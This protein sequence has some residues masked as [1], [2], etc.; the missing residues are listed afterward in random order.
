MRTA[1]PVP[2]RRRGSALLTVV[3]LTAAMAVLTASMLRYTLTERRG[4]E[5]NRLTLRAKNMAESISTYAAEQITTK[6]YRLRSTSAI[7]FIGGSNQIDPPPVSFLQAAN[8][9]YTSGNAMDVYA[10]LTSATGLVFVDPATKPN[11]PN[12]GLQVNTASVPIISKATAWHPALGNIVSYAQQDLAVDFVPL[13]QFAVFYNMDLEVWPGADLTI[14]G[15]VHV[16]GEFSARSQVGLSANIS[17]LERTSSSRGFYADTSRQGSWTNNLGV[18]NSGAG[19]DGSVNFRH[20]TT[21]ATTSVK[22]SSGVWRD[23][24]YG[25]ASETTTTQNNF[26]VFATS[27]YATNLRTSVHGVT[28]LSL[29]SVSN[30]ARTDNP[31]TGEDERSNGRQVIERPLTTDTSGLKETKISR[32]AGLYIVVNPD[33]EDRNGRMPDGT[34]FSMRAR[35]Y[36]CWLNTVNADLSHTIYEV[37]L[38]GQPSYGPLNANVNNL[39]NRYRTDTAVGHN[40]VLRTIQGGGVDAAGTGYGLGAAAPTMAS[41]GDAYFYDLRRAHNNSGLAAQSASGSFRSSNP[42]TPRPIVKIDFDMTRFRMCVERTMSGSSGNYLATD[43][44][45]TVYD[46]GVPTAANWANS[47]FNINATQASLGLGL[48]GGFSTLPTATTLTAPDPYRIYFAPAN[49]ANPLILSNPGTFAVGASDLVSNSSVKPWFDGITVYIHSVHAERRRD[50]DGDGNPDRI[51]SGVRFWNGRGPVI[52]LDGSVYP[53]KTGCT[54]CTNDAAYI[55]GH[56][57]ANGGAV[58]TTSSFG[59]NSSSSST[60]NGG[61]SA[62]YPDSSAEKLTA[63]MADAVTIVSQ[64]Y[65]TNAT[66]PYTQISGWSDSLSAHRTSATGWSA[67]WQTTQPSN[68]NPRD[69]IGTSIQ[70]AALPNLGNAVA[71]AGAARS[72][73][74]APNAT[75][76]STCFMVGI[77]PT[78]HNPTGLTD[79]PPSTGANGQ[80]SGGLHNFPRLLEVWGTAGLFIRGAMV[81]MYESRVAMEPWSLRIYAAPPRTWGLHENLRTASHDVPLEPILLGARRLGF[82]EITAAEY[83]AMKTTIEALPH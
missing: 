24:K 70:P 52:S 40:Q 45:A 83:T 28:A 7:A 64:P 82:K 60:G 27:T 51:D 73:K 22:N 23:H 37:V 79:G 33:D 63:V 15:P 21:L 62:R 31:A 58:G 46:V 66:V 56:F 54:I 61:F 35:S 14:A 25:S 26:K 32:R 20:T 81:A 68:A 49:P 59:I 16:N 36:R 76:I 18:T 69:G 50:S 65:F 9:A 30:Y 1:Y 53:S 29:P 41:F 11:D 75:E 57:N 2:F 12:A 17:F 74:F 10:G 13:F 5:R 72:E 38:P 4:N 67:T 34:L 55:V 8:P 77:V 42:Y 3:M 43:T 80:A 47:I 78:N 44:T 48:G 19:G 39:P 6:L 71:G